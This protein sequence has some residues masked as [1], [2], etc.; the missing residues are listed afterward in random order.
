M[1]GSERI[2]QPA[3]H[4][5][6]RRVSLTRVLVRRDSCGPWIVFVALSFI[7][8][9]FELAALLCVAPRAYPVCKEILG[10]ADRKIED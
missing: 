4:K 2:N 8:V 6:K 3:K 9:D 1:R 10:A 7:F 5:T